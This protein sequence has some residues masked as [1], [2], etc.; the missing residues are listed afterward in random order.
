MKTDSENATRHPQTATD[1]VGW[2]ETHTRQRG[3][4][5]KPPPCVLRAPTAREDHQLLPD[6]C[7][8]QRPTKSISQRHWQAPHHPECWPLARPHSGPHLRK[9]V[10]FTICCSLGMSSFPHFLRLPH[11]LNSLFLFIA[12]ASSS[13]DSAIIKARVMLSDMCLEILC[14]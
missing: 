1:D 3:Q 6:L 12:V 13:F 10:I 7:L 11:N 8:Q 5:G 2:G 4:P 9:A 14:M